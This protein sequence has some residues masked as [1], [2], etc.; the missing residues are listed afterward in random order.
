MEV[1]RVASDFVDLAAID[2]DSKDPRKAGTLTEIAGYND[3][4][5]FDEVSSVKDNNYD[6]YNVLKDLKAGDEVAVFC[7]GASISHLSKISHPV[8]SSRLFFESNIFFM[9]GKSLL[10]VAR[11]II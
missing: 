10:S 9:S 8:R 7:N 1:D 6:P 11:R 4:S 5:L 2:S 3:Y